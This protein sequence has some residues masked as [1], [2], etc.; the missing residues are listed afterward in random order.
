M[1]V[2]RKWSH[3]PGFEVILRSKFTSLLTILENVNHVIH[4][5]L[6]RNTLLDFWKYIHRFYLFRLYYINYESTCTN[7]YVHIMT[8]NNV[9]FNPIWSCMFNYGKRGYHNESFA[10]LPYYGQTIVAITMPNL[11][12]MRQR[13]PNTRRHAR[14]ETRWQAARC[15]CQQIKTVTWTHNPMKLKHWLAAAGAAVTA[16]TTRT[17]LHMLFFLKHGLAIS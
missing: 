17:T 5:H 1:A 10:F 8:Y 6:E 12:R 16:R 14:P 15:P 4:V 13:A 7:M 2:T 11:W 9:I 3:A